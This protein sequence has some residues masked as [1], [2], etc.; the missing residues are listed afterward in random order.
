MVS[1]WVVGQYFVDSKRKEYVAVPLLV[2]VVVNTVTITSKQ[3]S[4]QSMD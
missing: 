3:I 2:L 1:E 4:Y